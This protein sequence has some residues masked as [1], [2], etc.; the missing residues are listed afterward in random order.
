MQAYEELKVDIADGYQAYARFWTHQGDM[1]G[2][3]L[4]QHGIQ[5]HCGWYETS[6]R[7]LAEAGYDV[8]Q[9]D[10][11]GSGLNTRDRGHAES[12][13]QLLEDARLAQAHLLDRTNCAACHLVGVSWGGKLVA[14]SYAANPHRTLSLSLVTPGLFPKVGVSGQTMAKIG[15]AMLYERKQLFD[16]PLNDPDLFT[17]VP[18]WQQF[19]R[20]DKPT[21]RQC[22]AGFYLASRRMDKIIQGLGD[23]PAVPVHLLLAGDERIVDNGKTEA[24]VDRLCWP[25]TKITMYETARHSL[26]FEDDPEIYFRDLV[27]FITDVDDRRA[28]R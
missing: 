8:L 23:R 14:G 20:E 16:I 5:S 25:G 11:R 10:R 7:R 27:S 15:M 28:T 4:Y 13:D 3:V 22:T 6:A 12:A 24:F 2:S 17:T 26:E 18:K 1:R 19:F 9:I 21:L